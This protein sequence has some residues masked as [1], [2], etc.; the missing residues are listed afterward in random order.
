MRKVA[1]IAV[2]PFPRIGQMGRLVRTLLPTSRLYES[3][4]V[5]QHDRLGAVA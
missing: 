2:L 5:S 4:L 1:K 3:R